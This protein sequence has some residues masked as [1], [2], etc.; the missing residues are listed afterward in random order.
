MRDTGSSGTLVKECR[1]GMVT[2]CKRL[3]SGQTWEYFYTTFGIFCERDAFVQVQ[4]L[5]LKQK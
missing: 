2:V 1:D 3:Q 4:L 5:D